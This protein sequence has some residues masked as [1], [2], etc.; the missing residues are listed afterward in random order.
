MTVYQHSGDKRH[1]IS[2]RKAALQCLNVSSFPSSDVGG[3]LNGHLLLGHDFFGRQSSI[4]S[5]V[6]E[7]R[8]DREDSFV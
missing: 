5:A 2:Y 8:T 6:V 3:C 7:R 1:Q 4:L